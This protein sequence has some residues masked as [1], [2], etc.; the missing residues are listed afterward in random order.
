MTRCYPLFYQLLLD[1]SDLVCSGQLSLCACA[2]PNLSCDTLVYLT[3]PHLVLYYYV[4]LLLFVPSSV[5]FS[6]VRSSR[7]RRRV[8]LEVS[9]TARLH[10]GARVRGEGHG[11]LNLT[12]PF[13][14]VSVQFMSFHF[15]NVGGWGFVRTA[16]IQLFRLRFGVVGRA[17]SWNA[18]KTSRTGCCVVSGE[19][20]ISLSWSRWNL[21]EPAE[22]CL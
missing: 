7:R 2:L 16:I 3:R 1:L 11:H 21:G 22:M 17:W 12:E 5:F 14:F 10:Y 9:R 19:S 6:Q 13:R 4:L 15:M 8:H 18:V 20:R